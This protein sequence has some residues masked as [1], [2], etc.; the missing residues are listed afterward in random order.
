MLQRVARARSLKST[1]VSFDATALDANAAVKTIVRRDT[2]ESYAEYLKLL[3][4]IAGLEKY[5][6]AMLRRMD[7]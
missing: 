4:D 5:D 7:G 6:Q 2:E 1:T 3:A